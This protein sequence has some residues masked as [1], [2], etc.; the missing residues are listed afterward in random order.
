MG[1]AATLLV[2]GFKTG[3]SVV[4]RGRRGTLWHYNM[5]H[6][7]SKVVL[8]WQAQYSCD[9]FRRCVALFVASASLWRPRAAGTALSTY[10]VAHFFPNLNVKAARSGDTH[11]ST[12][13]TSHSTLYAFHSTLHTQHPTLYAPDLTLYTPHLI[14][15][16]LY[17]TLHASHFLLHIVHFTLHTLHSTVYTPFLFS[18]NY[19]SGVRCHTCEHSGSWVSSFFCYEWCCNQIFAKSCVLHRALLDIVSFSKNQKIQRRITQNWSFFSPGQSFG[20]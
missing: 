8:V 14:L 18:H 1:E 10:R 4:L 7:V 12:L 6:D 13:Y 16:T 19:D 9:V 11:H 2:E 17:F 20:E 15:H 3:C 5:C